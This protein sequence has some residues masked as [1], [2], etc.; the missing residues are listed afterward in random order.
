MC[1]NKT[2]NSWLDACAGASWSELTKRTSTLFENLLR[3]PDAP[4]SPLLPSF[5]TTKD[6]VPRRTLDTSDP[7]LLPEKFN[8]RPIE[9]DVRTI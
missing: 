9:I 4:G 6:T 3:K 5:T 2:N 8:V 7:I 1:V